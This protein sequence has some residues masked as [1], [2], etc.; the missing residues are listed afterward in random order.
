[1]F[2]FIRTK[3]SVKLS[4]P[5]GK[6]TQKSNDPERHVYIL[7]MCICH[8]CI[9]AFY[10]KY[11]AFTSICRATTFRGCVVIDDFDLTNHHPFLSESSHLRDIKI[12]ILGKYLYGLVKTLTQVFE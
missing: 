1:M 3:E 10:K 2:L 8:K 7:C 9:M 6:L 5:I 12:L 11:G 4:S